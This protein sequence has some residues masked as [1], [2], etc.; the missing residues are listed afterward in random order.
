MND[1]DIEL[2]SSLIAGDLPP[3]QAAE[4]RARIEA[5]NELGAAYDEQLAVATTLRTVPAAAMTAEE[6]S[7]LHATLRS[8]LR[9]DD[10][11][12]PVAAASHR[13]W[14][15]LGGLATAAAAVFAFAVV[16]SIL[17][18]DADIAGAPSA[19]QTTAALDTLSNGD[20]EAFE[21]PEA[22]STT[23]AASE[24]DGATLAPDTTQP[25]TTTAV[26]EQPAVTETTEAE[27]S[28]PM[29]FL[30]PVTARSD[31]FNLPVLDE[32]LIAA[33][34]LEAAIAEATEFIALPIAALSACFTGE[35]GTG[36]TAL[37][38]AGIDAE[39]SEVYAMAMEVE[40]GAQETVTIDLDTCS[41]TGAG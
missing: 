1:A 41:V 34:G 26:T 2:I 37:T 38:P 4:A 22:V 8:E 20:A 3:E 14:F 23:A 11:P 13:W 16:P 19:D 27:A 40:S 30:S 35:P 12:A 18:N 25:L 32:D 7:A 21:Q 9:L 15:A 33:S 6:R 31:A 36:D 24:G 28:S 39:E 29:Y 17:D 5:S 10:A